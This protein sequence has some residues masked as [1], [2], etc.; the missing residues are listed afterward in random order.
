[1]NDNKRRGLLRFIGRVLVLLFVQVVALAIMAWLLSGLQVEGVWTAVV[2]VGAIALLNA[3]L[4][5]LLSYLILPFAVLTLGLASLALNGA[6]ILL[7]SALVDGFSVDG[8]GTAVLLALGLTAINGILG[9]LL[10]IDD[11]SAWYRNVLRRQMRRRQDVVPTEEP[12]FLFL[13]FDGLARPVLERAMAQG[14]APTLRRWLETG[15]HRLVGWETDLSSQTSASQAGILHGNNDNIPAFRWYDRAA[16]EIVSSSNPRLLPGL[17]GAVSDGNGL[18][19]EEGASRGNMFSGD[20]PSVMNTASTMLDR[21]RF[22]TADFGAFF[23]HPYNFSRTLLLTVWEIVLEIWQFR[24]A[25]REGVYPLS[26]KEHRGG[27]YPLLRAVTTV[28]MRELNL[29]TLLGDVYAGVPAAYATFVGYDEVAHHSGVESQDA[30]DVLAKLDR[31]LAR[32]E[33]ALREAPRPYHLVVLSDHGQTSGATFKQRYGLTLEDLVR[34]LARETYQVQGD[35][36]VHEDWGH[37]NIM[38][39]EAVQ[40]GQGAVSKPLGRVLK[41][42]S[43]E[44]QVA[45]GPE[46]AAQAGGGGTRDGAEEWEPGSTVI[47]LASGNLGLVYGTRIPERATLE[48]IETYYPGLLDGLAQHEGIGFVMVRSEADG[49]VVIGGGGRHYLDDGR[50][51]GK[52]P[53]ASFGPNAARHLQRYD[54]FADAPDLYVSSF[55]DPETGEGAA[56]EEQIGFHGGLG[57]PQTQPF[58][59]FPS[60]LP[61]PD[62]P[63]VGAAAVHRVLKSWVSPGS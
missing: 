37:L 46:G 35:V 62:E 40:Y 60:I 51:E 23:L 61:L 19:V 34:Q 57:G 44:G 7:A 56:F 63:L 16:G 59:L 3:L 52:D 2:A 33:T 32:L 25:R 41:G 8:L 24:R 28:L 55:Y 53:L 47:V 13:E 1:M 22:H 42:R 6:L 15:S 31:Q 29:Y 21:S 17:E 20:A 54:G 30:F 36:D 11:D 10:N 39:T 43:R 50:L 9:S 48:Q 26:D 14:Y 5:P 18:L 38:L 45:L 4:W 27:I 12:G 58:L 49:P